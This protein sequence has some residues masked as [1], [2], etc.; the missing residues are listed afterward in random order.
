[1]EFDYEKPPDGISSPLDDLEPSV[2]DEV[3][4]DIWSR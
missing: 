1:M 2:Y 3:P 4:E